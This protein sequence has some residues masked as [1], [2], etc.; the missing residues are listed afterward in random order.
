[1]HQRINLVVYQKDQWN[2]YKLL[3]DWWRGLEEKK[4][5]QMIY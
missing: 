4:D 3:G 2:L 5:L 1:M